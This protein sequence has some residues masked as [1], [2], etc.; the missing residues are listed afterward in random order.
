MNYAGPVLLDGWGGGGGGA[1]GA[2]GGGGGGGGGARRLQQVVIVKPNTSY[3]IGIGQ[4]GVGGSVTWN[5]QTGFGQ[6]GG[7]TTFG[8]LAKFAGGGGGNSGGSIGGGYGGL[9]A[10]LVQHHN[11]VPNMGYVPGYP[12]GFGGGAGFGGGYASDDAD[13]LWSGG[14]YSGG[15]GAGAAGPGGNGG[16]GGTPTSPG[17]SPA[18]N[19]GGGGGGG[20]ATGGQN[21]GNGASGQLS[22]T[23]WT[24]AVAYQ[25][26]TSNGT[27]TAPPGYKGQVLL[28]GCGGG[29]G[30]GSEGVGGGGSQLGVCWVNVEPGISYAVTVGSGGLGGM[31]TN[32]A[33]TAGVKGQETSFGS[34]ASFLGGAPGF[35][36]PVSDYAGGWIE[37]SGSNIGYMYA[38]VGGVGDNY[39][40]DASY[41][42]FWGGFNA[43][44]NASTD[45]VQGGGG[46]GPYGNGPDVTDNALGN[47]AAA[48]TGAGGGGGHFTAVSQGGNGGSG[49]LIVVWFP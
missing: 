19:T 34:L 7:N 46:A 15:G 40:F 33:G 8:T 42:G 9:D 1:Y 48:N 2:G 12:N 16:N 38:G 5:G 10:P 32:H 14:T 39:Q 30:A 18:A 28:C 41:P 3:A 6:S 36:V 22:V 11:N 24:G 21:I 25:V 35:G 26:F 20:A 13:L 44:A 31:T 45:G 17:T 23:W 4:G 29:G 37:P 43:G 49:Q 47:S 27:W